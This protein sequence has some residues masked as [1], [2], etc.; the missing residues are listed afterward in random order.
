MG[1]NLGFVDSNRNLNTGESVS[2][3][4]RRLMMADE[5]MTMD[6]SEQL[7]LVSGQQPVIT[8]KVFYPTDPEF[9]GLFLDNPM[10]RT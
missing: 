2:E 10:F 3:T 6:A 9:Q 5:V 4:G 8:K 7:L 1:Q